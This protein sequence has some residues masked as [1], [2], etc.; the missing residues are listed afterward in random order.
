MAKL[1]GKHCKIKCLSGA[2]PAQTA[3]VQMKSFTWTGLECRQTELTGL[4]DDN[5]IYDGTTLD[6]GTV[7]GSFWYDSD[8][9][10]HISLMSIFK[11]HTT[12]TFVIELT[13]T[14]KTFTFEGLVTNFDPV[15]EANTD[16]FIEGSFTIKVSGLP[17][18]S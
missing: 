5:A 2:T 3:I 17:V 1:R 12:S 10:T 16:G 4:D 14:L 13:N 15:G 7:S 18:N 9:P 11:L 8:A 6:W